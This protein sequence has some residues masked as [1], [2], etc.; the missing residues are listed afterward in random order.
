MNKSILLALSVIACAI[1]NARAQSVIS[2]NENNGNNIPAAGV[3]GVVAATNWN[4]SINGISLNYD[5]GAASGAGFTIGGSWGA[6]G[7]T[8]FGSPDGDGTYN[9]TL[10]GGYANTSSGIGPE[11]FSITGI[12]YSV[13]DLIVY[14]SSDTAGRT[15][16]IASANAGITYD[17]TTMAFSEFTS[18]GAGGTAIFSQTTD[19]TLANPAADYAVFSNLTGSSDTLTL[20]IPDGGGIAG[21]Q[22]TPVPE[23]GTIT[24]AALTGLGLVFRRRRSRS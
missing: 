6:W 11:I 16:T 10:L 21:F 15:G 22:I 13:Y 20:N 19:T 8:A 1:V 4:N 17:F 14:I 23:P 5:N 3:A 9:R 7:I 24:L 2:W 18:T 12:P